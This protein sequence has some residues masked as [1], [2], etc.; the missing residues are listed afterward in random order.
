VRTN[1]KKKKKKRKERK[2]D[3]LLVHRWQTLYSHFFT[4]IN[5]GIGRQQSAE[6]CLLITQQKEKN[7]TFGTKM[8]PGN[9]PL[10]NS[11]CL[12]HWEYL[13]VTSLSLGLAL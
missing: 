11:N 3:H 8:A 4:F 10:F 9:G 6:K 7:V 5:S 13:H 12:N 1:T 2:K